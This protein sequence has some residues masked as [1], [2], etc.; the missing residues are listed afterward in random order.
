MATRKTRRRDLDCTSTRA[1][2]HPRAACTA[3]ISPISSVCSLLPSVSQPGNG[4]RRIGAG[5][6]GEHRA[7][8]GQRHVV[9]SRLTAAA[10]GREHA[11]W[12]ENPRQRLPRSECSPESPSREQRSNSKEPRRG[13]GSAMMSGRAGCAAPSAWGACSYAKQQQETASSVVLCSGITYDS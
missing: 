13:R 2:R 7:R 6:Q 4:R 1:E 10:N 11:N 5:T 12:N 8:D 9:I 3:P